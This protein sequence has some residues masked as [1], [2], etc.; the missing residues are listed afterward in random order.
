MSL[1]CP[2]RHTKRIRGGKDIRGVAS[3]ARRRGPSS[4]VGERARG[5]DRLG[6]KRCP[7]LLEKVGVIRKGVLW[8]HGGSLGTRGGARSMRTTLRRRHRRM[9]SNIPGLALNAGFKP[10]APRGHAM[11]HLRGG[12]HHWRPSSAA[13]S[14][15][16]GAAR[17]RARAADRRDAALGGDCSVEARRSRWW[18]H[19]GAR[20]TGDLRTGVDSESAVWRQKSTRKPAR[21]EEAPQWRADRRPR[22]VGPFTSGGRPG[23]GCRRQRCQ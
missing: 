11:C 2:Y 23:R 7:E 20:S 18:P 17:G 1:A 6:R 15:A 4:P 14:L 19:V 13:I 9:F 22:P 10:S 12:V 3:R 8:L 16:L 5:A 21:R